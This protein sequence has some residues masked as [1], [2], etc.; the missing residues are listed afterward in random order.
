MIHIF[1]YL[2]NREILVT[3]T[4]IFWGTSIRFCAREDAKSKVQ[5]EIKEQNYKVEIVWSIHV[6]FLSP[7]II[8]NKIPNGTERKT[9]MILTEKET[10]NL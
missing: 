2:S 7:A 6:F 3:S 8:P 5:G 10:G 9:E 4:N 1:I